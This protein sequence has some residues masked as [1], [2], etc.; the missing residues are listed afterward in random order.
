MLV[1]VEWIREYVDFDLAPEALAEQLTMAGLE[2]EE[3][4]DIAGQKV[5]ATYV[6]PNRSDLLSVIGVARNI[7]ALCD[8]PLKLPTVEATEGETEIQGLVSVDVQSPANC[9]RYSTRVITGVKIV[10][11]P[12]WMQ[13]RLIA[14]GMRP[15]NN[16]VDATNYV[17]L[18]MGQP[19]HAFD[20][21]LVADHKIIVRQAA[22][23]E[24]IT[25]ID[26][27]E[28]ELNPKV[29][30]IAD[31]KRPIAVAGVM[32]G[33]HSEVS[34]KTTNVLLE[35]AH[36]NRLSIRRTA[37]FLGMS[38]EA[39]Y[40]FERWVDPNITILALDR[41]AQLIQ[42]TG[43]GMIA[44]GIVDVYPTEIAPVK[45]TIRS[46][47]ASKILGFEVTST[48]VEDS[49]TRLGM[50]V[51][52]KDAD[53]LEVTVPTFRPDITREEDLIEEVGI[54]Y[55]YENIPETLPVGASMLG[56]DSDEGLF[57]A[58]ITNVLT[59]AGL[60][61]VTTSS[62]V[63]PAEGVEQVSIRNPLSEDVSKL[64]STLLL[65]L[66]EVV[67]YNSGRGIRDIG[68]FEIG[69]VFGS[70]DDSLLVE[71]LSVGAAITGSLWGQTWNVDRTSLDVDFF[72]L[73]GITEDLF[74]RLGVRDVVYKP[75]ELNDF[76]PTRAAVIEV[77]NTRLGVMGQIN[78]QTAARCDVPERTY[79]F[80]LDFNQL[81]ELSGQSAAY[82]PLSRYPA[83]TRDLAV[84]LADTVP[85]HRVAELITNEGGDLLESLTL[86][87]VYTGAPLLPGQKNLAFS[88]VFRS[89]E[90]TLRDQE[91]DDSLVR[92]RQLLTTELNASFRDT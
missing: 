81:M 76:H 17:L 50:S 67:S 61:E 36:F 54:I 42:E 40:R 68:V 83:V 8:T 38:T 72:L 4:K 53:T 11:S 45:A 21:D 49:L 74:E 30:V 26:G 43:G 23:G 10:T 51:S 56:R 62:M 1:P 48:Q 69:H 71:K 7:S 66:L 58:R 65:D 29:L 92:I 52:I 59:S 6:T 80:E 16:V 32:G 12:K 25:T 39:S 63:S 24:K 35:S 15:I 2:V 13:E 87:D 55:G 64:R 28:R 46:S 91:V 78:P 5:F 33:F 85:Y 3:I 19:L 90:R 27:E 82:Q 75:A 47:R 88:V 37:R 44:K 34:S 60:Q 18:E 84:V 89:R 14:A 31:A 20:Y 86:F 57:G 73:K 79:V 22:A 9:P 41:V 70:Q 77:E